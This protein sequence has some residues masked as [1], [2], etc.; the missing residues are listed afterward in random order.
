[1]SRNTAEGEPR[2][3]PPDAARKPK[4]PPGSPA[5]GKKSAAGK[6]PGGA[7]KRGA[8]AA[9]GSAERQAPKPRLWMV[10][11]EYALGLAMLGGAAWWAARYV[12]ETAIR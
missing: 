8:R 2:A 10:V 7:G 11:V 1:M 6:G 12:A 5:K 4:P 3:N 9:R